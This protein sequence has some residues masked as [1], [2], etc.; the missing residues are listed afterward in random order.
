[1]KKQ[2]IAHGTRIKKH[3]YFVYGWTRNIISLILIFTS[4]AILFLFAWYSPR[5]IFPNILGIENPVAATTILSTI[6]ST[7][8][9]I[10]GIIIVVLLVAFEILRKTYDYYALREFFQD[11]KFK[12]LFA[13]YLSTISISIISIATVNNQ[14]SVRSLNLFYSSAFLSFICITILYFYSKAILFSVSSEKRIKEIVGKIDFEAVSQFDKDVQ[15]TQPLSAYVQ[16]M[17]ENPIFLLS[18][19]A[20]RR[21]KDDDRLIPQ[22]VLVE[23]VKR[24]LGLI[25][26]PNDSHNKRTT[27]NAFLVIVE[28]SAHQAISKRQK[29]TLMTV[30]RVIEEIHS[31][32]AQNRLAWHEVIELNQIFQAILEQVMEANLDGV[33]RRGFWTIERIF[34]E[35]LKNNVPLESELQLFQTLKGSKKDIPY[36][37]EKELQ[38]E[39]VSNEYIKMLYELIKKAIELKKRELVFT[40]LRCFTRTASTIINL[41]L[42][43]LQKVGIVSWCYYYAEILTIRSADEG[44]YSKVLALSPF[45][46]LNISDALD[47]NTGFSKLPLEHFGETVIQ[48]AQREV[49]DIF[50]VNELGKI[51]ISVIKKIDV[52]DLHVE[53]LRYIL[54]IFDKTREILED[55][56]NKAENA[57]V[58]LEIFRETQG[59]MKSIERCNKHNEV[60]E[61]ELSSVLEKFKT[62][63]EVKRSSKGGTIKWP[64]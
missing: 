25:S 21:I 7:L 45:D 2:M 15:K 30:L 29:R 4:I 46:W 56:I 38:W 43:D 32:C 33:A 8:A 22:L 34:N 51:G 42:G 52:S 11:I 13:L 3:A 61:R 37:R 6:A 26:Q 63:E 1:M 55:K 16:S 50:D 31:F 54:R 57:N 62:P 20:I 17:K 27:I 35:H 40:G 58:Y 36:D 64:A 5:Q 23:S 59:L 47:K 53:A 14:L 41:K 48:L 9:S 19:V 49:L 39:N 18:E 10:L 12:Q 24:L 44:L 28:D 60:L